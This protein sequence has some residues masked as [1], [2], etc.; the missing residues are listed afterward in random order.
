[1]LYGVFQVLDIHIAEKDGQQSYIDFG[2]GNDATGFAGV[3]RFAVVRRSRESVEVHAQHVS[4]NPTVNKA[5]GPQWLFVF[6]KWYAYT[7][8]KEGVSEIVRGLGQ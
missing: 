7:L 6:H 4:C 3:H 5:L 1:M 2:F 8:F